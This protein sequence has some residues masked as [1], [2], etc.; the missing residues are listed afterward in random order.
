MTKEQNVSYS[1]AH[2]ATCTLQYH[3]YHIRVTHKLLLLD[4]NQSL[5][6][7]N[8]L[9]TN[10]MPVPTQPT[11]LNDFFPCEVWFSLFGYVNNRNNRYWAAN[12]P[13]VHLEALLYPEKIDV[14]CTLWDTK[15]IRPL[16]FTTTTVLQNEISR[17]PYFSNILNPYTPPKIHTQAIWVS[18]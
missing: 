12:N 18:N 3:L 14:W 9:L 11:L 6:Y 1:T 15:L 10:F 2:R 16:F 8:W 13:H 5:H 17:S 4:S 7:C